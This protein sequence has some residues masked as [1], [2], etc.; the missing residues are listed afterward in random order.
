MSGQVP[1]SGLV[2]EFNHLSSFMDKLYIVGKVIISSFQN[3]LQY[4]K[5]CGQ[6]FVILVTMAT[7]LIFGGNC[8]KCVFHR[9]FWKL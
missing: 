2:Y 7:K 1:K 3:W 8:G 4:K 5:V 9:Y 6:F